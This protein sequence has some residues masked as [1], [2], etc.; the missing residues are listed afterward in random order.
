ME[1]KFVEEYKKKMVRNYGFIPDKIEPQHYVFGSGK[2]GSEILTDGHW[3]EYLQPFEELQYNS[4]I[5]SYN[6]TGYGT[7]NCLTTLLKRKFFGTSDWLEDYADF[8]ERVIGILAHTKPP[9]NTPYNVA[10]AIRKGGLVAQKYLPFDETI[11]TIIQYFSPDPLTPE[12][13]EKGLSFKWGI[14]HE[15]VVNVSPTSLIEALKRSPLGVGVFG[16]QEKDGIYYRNGE[17]ANHWVA[18]VDFKE[19][20][21]WIIYDSY[22]ADGKPLKKLNWNYKF[23]SVR[24]YMI[25]DISF[26]PAN[27]AKKI[28][29]IQKLLVLFNQLLDLINAKYTQITKDTVITEL[30]PVE[31]PPEAPATLPEASKPIS[32][33]NDIALAV[34]IHEGWYQGSRS[35]RNFNPGN[36]RYSAY[37]K[38]LGALDKDDKNFCIFKTEEAGFNALCQLLKDAFNGLLIPYKNCENLQ[39]FFCV[40]APSFENDSVFYAKFVCE[41]T[42]IDIKTSLKD[43][44]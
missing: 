39:D 28:S 22:L 30:E 27:I 20:E 8:S 25:K 6:C 33:I 4:F 42:G 37:T 1:N 36:L 19:N 34:K 9:G 41:K 11:K 32:R 38:S 2:L 31:M 26:S 12:L 16:W 3:L 15:A 7:E 40:Y 35:F 13:I 29:I 18:L 21:Y 10:E 23:E 14:G 17:P 43:L 24:L 44:A 5:D